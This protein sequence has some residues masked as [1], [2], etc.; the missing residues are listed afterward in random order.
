MKR[1]FV[2]TTLLVIAVSLSCIVA[3]YAAADSRPLIGCLPV[4]DGIRPRTRCLGNPFRSGQQEAA[5][6]AVMETLRKGETDVLLPLLESTEPERKERIISNENKFRLTSWRIGD[7]S[8]S[9]T[10]S[11]IKYWTTRE[12]YDSVEEVRFH[13]ERVDQG[14]QLRSYSAVY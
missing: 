8:H 10:E 7:W 6:E 14:W 11:T 1:F 2:I 13:F 3:L 4:D 5:A 12:N 9:G